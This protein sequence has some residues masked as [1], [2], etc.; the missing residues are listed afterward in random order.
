MPINAG[1]ANQD[2]V[3]RALH[4][5]A[6]RGVFR[7]FTATASRRGPIAYEFLWLTRR[8]MRATFDPTRRTL[9]F[10]ALFPA[11]DAAVAAT[12]RSIAG[13]RTRREL[14][15]HKRLDTRRARISSTTSRGDFGLRVDIRGGNHDY[16]VGRGLNLINELFVALH[17]RHPEYLIEQFGVSAE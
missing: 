16:A 6:G 13:T 9:V 3:T 4:A 5:Y 1:A 12:L 2:P 8:P 10:P 17:E 15:P 14:P 7:G 11:V